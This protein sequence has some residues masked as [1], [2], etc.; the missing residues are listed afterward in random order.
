VFRSRPGEDS[1]GRIRESSR[2]LL[3]IR[4]LSNLVA[5]WPRPC[6]LFDQVKRPATG[7]IS[8]RSKVERRSSMLSLE[9]SLTMEPPLFSKLCSVVLKSPTKIRKAGLV[10]FRREKM[11][12]QQIYLSLFMEGI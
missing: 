8:M 4:N 9:A 5:M 7:Q 1:G 11:E 3:L 6:L 10:R 2:R 12:S